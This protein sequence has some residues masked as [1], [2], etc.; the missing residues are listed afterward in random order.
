MAE[1][2]T[3]FGALAPVVSCK[4]RYC[5]C[6]DPHT[7]VITDPRDDF[8]CDVCESCGGVIPGSVRPWDDEDDN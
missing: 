1:V 4:T 7:S 8:I 6:G 5:D 3:S 2:L